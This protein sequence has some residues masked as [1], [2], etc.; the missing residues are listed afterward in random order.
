MKLQSIYSRLANACVY[1]CAAVI[2]SVNYNCNG[3]K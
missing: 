1:S 2:I 3:S